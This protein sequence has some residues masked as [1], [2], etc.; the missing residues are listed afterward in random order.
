MSCTTQWILCCASARVRHAFMWSR[1]D[2][3][4]SSVTWMSQPV[5][6]YHRCLCYN[7]AFNWTCKGVTTGKC[8][9]TANLAITS[10]DHTECVAIFQ[11]G[12]VCWMEVTRE[13]PASDQVVNLRQPPEQVVLRLA[14]PP[15]WAQPSRHGNRSYHRLQQQDRGYKLLGQQ[16]KTIFCMMSLLFI[17]IAFHTRQAVVLCLCHLT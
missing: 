9:K 11:M 13:D 7:P 8:T 16:S 14:L 15:Q 12:G 3:Q 5:Q 2:F 10:T 6:T 4:I 17:F 1:H